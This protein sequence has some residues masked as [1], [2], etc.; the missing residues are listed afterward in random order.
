MP[1]Y[2]SAAFL[3]QTI[4]SLLNQTHTDSEIIVIDD[5]SKDDIYFI[6]EFYKENMF[7]KWVTMEQR[8]G[9]AACRNIGNKLSTGQIIAVCDAGDFYLPNRGEILDKYFTEN[10]DVSICYSHVQIDTPLNETL[11]IQEAIEWD[12]N[13]KPPISH[14]TVAYRSEVVQGSI[15]DK[16]SCDGLTYTCTTVPGIKYIEDSYE[17]DFYEF[18]MIKCFRQGYKFGIIPKVTCIKY[19]LSKSNSYRN[20]PKAKALKR[21]KYKEY[22]IKIESDKV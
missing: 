3:N 7:I 22:G 8:K 1:V 10:P 17:T 21:Q 9:A 6:K 14:P 12:G 4:N 19:D 15:S 5:G 20:V 13:S 2:N 16:L 11:G 18:F